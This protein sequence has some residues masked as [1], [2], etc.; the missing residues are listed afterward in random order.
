MVI[1]KIFEVIGWTISNSYYDSTLC[2][3]AENNNQTILQMKTQSI[4]TG[5]DFSTIW[6]INATNNEY[7]SL[8]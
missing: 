7:P 5:F 2:N 6:K 8:I 4:F 3:L 1:L